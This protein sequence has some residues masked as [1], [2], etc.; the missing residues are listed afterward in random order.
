MK[1]IHYIMT[2]RF[3]YFDIIPLGFMGTAISDAVDT[4]SFFP[5]FVGL[6]MILPFSAIAVW[7]EN[8]TKDTQND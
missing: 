3:A 4:Q 5:V 8:H 6:V 7:Y 1:V 2:K